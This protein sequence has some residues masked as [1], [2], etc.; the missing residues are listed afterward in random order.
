QRHPEDE[1]EGVEHAAADESPGAAVFLLRQAED[2]E[3]R[4]RRETVKFA[5]RLEAFPHSKPHDFLSWGGFVGWVRALPH[6]LL[7]ARPVGGPAPAPRLG[8]GCREPSN[9]R[10]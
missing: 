1:A 9:P 4:V 6:Q 7:G 10:A 5:F 3:Q 2:V 8:A